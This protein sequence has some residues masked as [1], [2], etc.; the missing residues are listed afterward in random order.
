MQEGF[1]DPPLKQII[2]PSHKRCPPSTRRKRTACLWRWRD[3]DGVWT[4]RPCSVSSS[5][6][7]LAFR[8]VTF[9]HDPLLLLKPGT[10]GRFWGLYFLWRLLY[11]IK[12][13]LNTFVCF[14]VANMS[15]V[16]GGLRWELRRVEEKDIFS[17]LHGV[18]KLQKDY[19]MPLRHFCISGSEDPNRLCHLDWPLR[20]GGCQVPWKTSLSLCPLPL[21]P[22]F[23]GLQAHV[24]S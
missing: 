1:S 10:E 12:L 11:H 5:S 7:A 17:P 16:L 6:L 8:P 3:A 2:R 20:Q 13:V 22:F 18:K 24:G 4:N 21:P 23:N 9:F 14:S 19:R 15:L